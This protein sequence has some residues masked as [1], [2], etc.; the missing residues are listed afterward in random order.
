M[1]HIIKFKNNE[2]ME[3]FR[4]QKIHIIKALR[5]ATCHVDNL[6]N[7]S[8]RMGLKEAKDIADVLVE[9]G[10]VDFTEWAMKVNNIEHLDQFGLVVVGVKNVCSH[11]VIDALVAQAKNYLDKGEFH[12]VQSI[13]EAL[14]IL[15]ED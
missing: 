1:S 8:S 10:R 14:I 11:V 12:S 9:T 13:M 2:C 7:R 6:G 3:V 15:T 4:N 5:E